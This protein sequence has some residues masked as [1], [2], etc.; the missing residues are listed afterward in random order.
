[1]NVPALAKTIEGLF[2]NLK[3]KNSKESIGQIFGVQSKNTFLIKLSENRTETT[4]IFDFV[5]FKYSIDNKIR[6]GLILDVYLLNQEQWVKVLTTPEI[7]KIFSNTNQLTSHTP[8]LVYKI[9][10]IP[11]TDYLER[12]IGLVTENSNIEKIR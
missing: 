9:S 12:F 1:L 3:E 10:N 11:S 2:I 5:E 6:K 8:D 4:K 7:E